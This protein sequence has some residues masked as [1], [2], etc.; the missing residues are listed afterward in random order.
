MHYTSAH[1][2]LLLCWRG[3]HSPLHPPPNF[4][5]KIIMGTTLESGTATGLAQGPSKAQKLNVVHYQN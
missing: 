3:G 2:G 4:G 5:R 1:R